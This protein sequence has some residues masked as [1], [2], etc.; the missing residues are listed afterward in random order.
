MNQVKD[1]LARDLDS[2]VEEADAEQNKAPVEESKPSNNSGDVDALD[3]FL[4]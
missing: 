1:F 2:F 4:N 3:Q